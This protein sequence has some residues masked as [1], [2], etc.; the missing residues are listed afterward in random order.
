[1]EKVGIFFGHLEYILQPFGTIL[2]AVYNLVTVWYILLRFGI[3]CREK[4][5]NP[6]FYVDWQFQKVL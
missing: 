2:W 5:G 4:S 3:L 6:G 1:M